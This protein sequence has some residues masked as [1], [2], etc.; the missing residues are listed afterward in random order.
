MEEIEE[1]EEN[2]NQI[3][4]DKTFNRLKN[5]Q[6]LIKKESSIRGLCNYYI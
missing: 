6:F 5:I 3:N 1:K 2:N 4:K